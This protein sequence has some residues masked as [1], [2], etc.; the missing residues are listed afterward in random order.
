MSKKEII[1]GGDK[2][3]QKKSITFYDETM[4]DGPQSLWAARFD[5]GMVDAVAD[6]IDQAGFTGTSF[7]PFE[8][9]AVRRGEDPWETLRLI[10]RKLKKTMATTITAPCLVDYMN[11]PFDPPAI[12]KL[13]M[14]NHTRLA[15]LRCVNMMANPADEYKRFMP[16]FIPFMKGLGVESYPGICYFPSPRHNDEFFINVAKDVLKAKPDRIYLKDAGGLLTLERLKGIL[17]TMIEDANAQGV[18]VGIHTHCVS[19]NAGQVIVEAM[20]LGVDEVVTCVPPLANG[21]SH[22]SIFDALHNAKILGIETNIDEK[23]LRVVE[24]RLTAIAKQENLLI[25]VPLAYDHAVYQH[26]IPGGV[27][28]TLRG[29]LGIIGKSDKLEEVLEEVPRVLEDLGYP[30]MITPFSQ[31]VVTQSTINVLTGERYKEIVDRLIDLALGM[32]GVECSGFLY[33]DQNL[34][35]RL[36]SDPNTKKKTQVWEKMQEEYAANLPLKHYK[37]KYNMANASDED[38]LLYYIMY[39]DAEIKKMREAGPPKSYKNLFNMK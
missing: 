12:W 20:K 34:K 9:V 36:L 4:R 17:P 26:Q 25:G 23:P 37:A 35:D 16:E 1:K 7:H 6:L 15:G 2:A 5:Y 33:M 28:G 24:E 32:Y 29:Q 19:C 38:F 31:F 18:P 3:M 10:K 22:V 11:K 21:T 30:I 13:Y 39:G 14:E 27:M 8:N